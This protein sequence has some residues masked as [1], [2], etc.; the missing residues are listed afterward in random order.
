[1]GTTLPEVTEIKG[2]YRNWICKTQALLSHEE[3]PFPSESK[4]RIYLDQC[5]HHTHKGPG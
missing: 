3:A 1:M 5:T 2:V 4:T